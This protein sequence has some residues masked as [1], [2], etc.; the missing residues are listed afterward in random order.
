MGATVTRLADD[1][2]LVRDFAAHLERAVADIGAL[3]APEREA[4]YRLVGRAFAAALAKVHGDG[5]DARA[6]AAALSS[7]ALRRFIG[8]QKPQVL[9]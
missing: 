4:C 8:A 2:R 9:Q 1:E 7:G 5:R 6:C 3:P